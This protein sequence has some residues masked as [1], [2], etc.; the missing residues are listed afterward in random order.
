[1]SAS[2]HASPSVSSSSTLSPQRTT[3]SSSSSSSSFHLKHYNEDPNF[4]RQRFD[5][6][7]LVAEDGESIQK[8]FADAMRQRGFWFVHINHN[9]IDSCMIISTYV[10][11]ESI[12]FHHHLQYCSHACLLSAAPSRAVL[13]RPIVAAAA[14]TDAQVE[15][16]RGGE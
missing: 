15:A 4:D 10:H 8:D 6:D 9:V 7:I 11:F 2:T 16:P 14:H 13:G 3:S 5:W 1:V 12:R